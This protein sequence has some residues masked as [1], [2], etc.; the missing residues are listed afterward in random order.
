MSKKGQKIIKKRAIFAS[1]F[2]S[3]TG[4]AWDSK[5]ET[6]FGAARVPKGGP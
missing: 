5:D 1:E 6:E 4:S 2:E 3:E